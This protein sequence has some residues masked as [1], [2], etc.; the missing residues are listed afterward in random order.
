MPRRVKQLDLFA[1]VRDRGKPVATSLTHLAEQ[2]KVNCKDGSQENNQSDVVKQ[3]LPQ[4]KIASL[5]VCVLGS[6]SGGN[7]TLIQYGSQAM[8]LDA[9][10]GPVTTARRLAQI[11]RTVVDT[12]IN[13]P[14]HAS[15]TPTSKP[16]PSIQ[17]GLTPGDIKAICLTH[18]DQDHFRPTWIRTL[19]KHGIRV[20]LHR[21]HLR[22]LD[23]IERAG[24]LHDAGLVHL[25]DDDPFEPI[26][27]VTANTV[28]LPHDDKGTRGYRLQTAN[29]C[30]GYATDLGHV[31]DELIKLLAGVDMLMLESNYDPHM[32]LTSERPYFLKQRVMGKHGHLSNEQALAAT[33]QITDTSSRGNPQRIILL[34]RSS[35]CNTEQL[36]KETFA[37]DGRF[38]KRI[39]HTQ[40][41]KRTQVIEVRPLNTLA[42]EQMGLGYDAQ[43]EL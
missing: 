43:T 23:R 19:I 35:Q 1:A 11:K 24:D 40:Q 26:D 25:F 42:R 37:V 8:L 39:I 28:A 18:L 10:F 6:G 22:Y 41:R 12:A 29:G 20:Y 30:V 14:S 21:W 4:G 31:P 7:S 5:K 15:Q 2:N 34:H 17:Q 9:G 32:Q 38:A 27:G 33:Q 13:S 3:D 16:V 36:V